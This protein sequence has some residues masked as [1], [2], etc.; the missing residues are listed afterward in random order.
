MSRFKYSLSGGVRLRVRSE[1]SGALVGAPRMRLPGVAPGQRG[2][3]ES[4]SRHGPSLPRL[5]FLNNRLEHVMAGPVTDPRAHTVGDRF[6]AALPPL[7]CLYG[8]G[9]GRG[10][11]RSVRRG[12]GRPRVLWF[13]VAGDRGA[14]A[15]G[16]GSSPGG[17]AISSGVSKEALSWRLHDLELIGDRPTT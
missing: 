1:S 10:S 4:A 9:D 3:P 14:A 15:S 2:Q 5:S 13:P 16:R 8:R 11:P 7:T 17:L 6:H 12:G